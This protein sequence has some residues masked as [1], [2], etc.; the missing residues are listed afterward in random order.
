MAPCCFLDNC[1]FK[2]P[3]L[4]WQSLCFVA[5]FD[6]RVLGNPLPL[7]YAASHANKV[8]LRPALD[9]WIILMWL[10]TWKFGNCF[11]NVIY[12]VREI[13]NWAVLCHCGAVSE[14]GS[15]PLNVVF[16]LRSLFVC[17]PF[18]CWTWAL[19]LISKKWTEKTC[20]PKRNKLQQHLPNSVRRSNKSDGKTST[21]CIQNSC[22]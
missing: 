16:S 7:K 21:P 3:L 1:F 4:L 20:S 11:F 15:L 12:F 19:S 17:C 18:L 2:K 8:L 13:E 22:C 6:L 10:T 5:G 9:A 14:T